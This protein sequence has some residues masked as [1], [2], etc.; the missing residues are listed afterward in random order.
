M[1]YSLKI[2]F[3]TV[4][5]LFFLP[6]FNT[7][8]AESLFKS[9]YDIVYSINPDLS[10]KTKLVIT[11]TNLRSDVY[12]NKFSLIIPLLSDVSDIS[13]TSPS[14][15]VLITTQKKD[16]GTK[17]EFVFEKPLNGK[18]I[19]NL[20]E[21]SFLESKLIQKDGN[22]VEVLLPSYGTDE[23]PTTVTLITNNLLP[24]LLSI[25]KPVPSKNS[26][27]TLTWE[28]VKTPIISLLFGKEQYYFLSLKYNLENTRPT[29]VQQDI[30][31]PPETLFQSVLVKK[32]SPEPDNYFLDTDGNYIG[33]Y[34]LN[35]LEKKKVLFE[36][37]VTI[38]AKQDDTMLPYTRSQF[39]R[40]KGYL[41]AQKQ[42][43]TINSKNILEAITDLNTPAQIFQFVTDKLDYSYA[44]ITSTK[45]R[46]G[47]EVAFYKPT[48]ALCTE[49]T[50]LFIAIS[51]EQGIPSREIQGYAYS[52]DPHLRPLSLL[53]DI[54]HAWPEYYDTVREAWIPVDPTWTDTSGIDY[55]HGFDLSHIALS[56]HGKDPVYPLPAG[57]YKT[58]RSQDV[59]VRT[60]Q[61]IPS[62]VQ[63]AQVF[64]S[65][66]IGKENTLNF[67][68]EVVNSGNSF[69]KNNEVMVS[70][71]DDL[72]DTKSYPI[73]LLAPG[74]IH[75]SQFNVTSNRKIKST[76]VI[77]VTISDFYNEDHTVS[78]KSD[79][80]LKNKSL[81][82]IITP[83][84]ILF[85]I[86]LLIKRR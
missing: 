3:L 71:K 12:V 13:A 10:V 75:T 63:N 31:F 66:K 9:T 39:E 21:V 53:S 38:Y 45:K 6:L 55:L 27:D 43:W 17:V 11:L 72:F 19:S 40:Q 28:N 64:I 48:M 51:R 16:N 30:A 23:T 80:I 70:S 86:I 8:R 25:A 46:D 33:R 62:K 85:V 83:I 79:L 74:Q 60:A 81:L 41:L 44:S 20:L 14:G 65:T 73:S 32:I 49:Y 1:K 42:Y 78:F 58:K 77:S 67:S 54:L 18:N 59:H 82:F 84:F 61:K 69:I 37:Y 56:V 22:V 36:G 29:K 4:F 2:L 76:E 50:D 24:G 5:L 7:L 26:L 68:V 34:T 47:A 15:P 52:Q 35:P 57:M